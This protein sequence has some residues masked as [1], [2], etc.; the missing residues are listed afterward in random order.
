MLWPAKREFTIP[1]FAPFHFALLR[2]TFIRTVS[3]PHISRRDGTPQRCSERCNHP[4]LIN[5]AAIFL[6]N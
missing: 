3:L 4:I 2:V 1:Q 5:T 6:F